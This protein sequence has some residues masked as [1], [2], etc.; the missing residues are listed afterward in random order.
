MACSAAVERGQ[1]ET[2][3]STPA[4][5][6]PHDAHRESPQEAIAVKVAQNGVA[7]PLALEPGR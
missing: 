1:R 2:P 3:E 7:S 5:D 4:L 6:E